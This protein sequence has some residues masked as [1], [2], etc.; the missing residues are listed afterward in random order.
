M[1]KIIVIGDPHFQSGNGAEVYQFI[2]KLEELCKKEQPEFIVLLGDILHT[3]ERLHSQALNMAVE[4]IDLLRQIA[5]V[6]LVVGNHDMINNQQFMTK[7]HWMNCLKGKKDLIVV[8]KLEK[9]ESKSGELYLFLP[10]LPVGRFREGLAGSDYKQAEIIFAHQEF[11]GC[12]MGAIS[13]L[14]G[15]RWGAEEPPVIS[16]HIHSNQRLEN[17]YYPGSSMQVAFGES[18]KNIIAVVET[19]KGENSLEKIKTKTKPNKTSPFPFSI[20]EVELDLPRKKII[21]TDMADIDSVKIK[22]KEGESKDTIKLTVSGNYEEFK[23]FKK[24]KKYKELIKTGTKV[25]FKSKKIEIKKSKEKLDSVAGETDFVKILGILV[26]SEKNPHLYLLH[27][28][29]VHD[30][31]IE[32]TDF[33][34]LDDK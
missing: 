3:H 30:R 12:K 26:N 11:F 18:D 4:M 27:E 16:G 9:Y 25:V 6:F 34:F 19:G 7:N 17:V 33:F 2:S 10:Y 14:E 23:A 28:K 29:V 32:A 5:P 8:D 31:E 21:Y 1:T 24:T 13:S 20:R 22:G 15:D